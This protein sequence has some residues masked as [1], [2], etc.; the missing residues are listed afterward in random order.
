MAKR[1]KDNAVIEEKPKRGR[2]KSSVNSK[3]ETSAK[4]KKKSKK[5]DVVDIETSIEQ[6]DN[7]ISNAYKDNNEELYTK[8]KDSYSFT[9]VESFEGYEPYTGNIKSN[10]QKKKLKSEKKDSYS[11][12]SKRCK[13]CK[14]EKPLSDFNKFWNK[15]K[16]THMDICKDCE[17]DK[18]RRNI[19]KKKEIVNDLKS[20]GCVVCGEKD[21]CCLD[22]HHIDSEH[23][24]FNM[25]SA[26]TKT[27]KRI[28]EEAAKCVVVCSNCH[29]KIHAGVIDIFDYV[30][31]A[32]YQYLRH[33]VNISQCNVENQ[34]ENFANWPH[35]G[36][37]DGNIN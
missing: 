15:D 21:P 19:D 25:G 17:K 30:N 12:V 29:R 6:Y 7:S 26:W 35:D 11:Y 36:N 18:T 2:K 20:C 31:P 28:V 3:K 32:Q 14:K 34:I 24:E 13:C 22:F 23:K 9:S 10:S 5:N 16:Q 1:K 27:D 33:L 8:S 37:D 4:S